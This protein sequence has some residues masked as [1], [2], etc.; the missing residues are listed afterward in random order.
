MK[1]CH[2]C[3][4]N[5]LW[6]ICAAAILCVSAGACA[7]SIHKVADIDGRITYTDRPETTPLPRAATVSDSDVL[8]APARN[9]LMTSMSAATVD[10]KE[11][12]RR[13]AR[14]RQS[15]REA[16]E[17]RRG[18]STDAAGVRMMNEYY[19]RDLQRL[20]REV[21][22]AQRRLNETSLARSALLRSDNG[23]DTIKLAQ[24]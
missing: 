7:Q 17:P 3:S 21:A 13:L 1:S 19:Q 24:P 10:F 8:S 9:S 4:L 18:E 15:R 12:T 5:A 20:D 11:A 6:R 23:T 16:L 2:N 22:A 14:A